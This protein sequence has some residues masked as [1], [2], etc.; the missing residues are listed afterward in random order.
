MIRTSLTSFAVAA[1]LLPCIVLAHGGGEESFEKRA[2]SR[3]VDIGYEDG[4]V[5]GQEALLDIALYETKNGAPTSLSDFTSVK[6]R[7]FS[8]SVVQ[9]EKLIVKTE[10][11]KVF[12]NFTP[13]KSGNWILSS[14]FSHDDKPMATAEFRLDIKPGSAAKD[15]ETVPVVPLFTVIIGL[16]G[17]TLWTLLRSQSL[18]R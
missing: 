12:A 7:V 14:D 16:L 3:L 9:Y 18:L 17:L 15:V 10:Q 8:G 5:V 13:T 11:N 2:G 1:A 6:L 4:F